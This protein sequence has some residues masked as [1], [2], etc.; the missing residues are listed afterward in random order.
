M[1]RAILAVAVLCLLGQPAQAEWFSFRCSFDCSGWR[2]CT[3][4]WCARCGDCMRSGGEKLSAAAAAT[5]DWVCERTGWFQSEAAPAPERHYGLDVPPEW[6]GQEPLIVLV[7]G[8][9]SG[10]DCW[11]DLAPLLTDSGYAVAYFNYPNDQPIAESGRLLSAELAAFRQQHDNVGLDLITHSMGGLVVR[12]CLEGAEYP[13]GV[14]RFIQLSPP[15]HG[16]KYR[17]WSCCAETFEHFL[18]WREF[19]DWNWSWPFDDGM[20]EAGHDLRADSTLLSELNA[21]PRRAGVAY[22]IVAGN[23]NCGWRYTANVLDWT[24]AWLP[25][26]AYDCGLRRCLLETAAQLRTRTGDSDGLVTLDSARLAGVDDFLVLPAD[27]LTICRSYDAAPPAAW[28]TIRH[29]LTRPG[30]KTPAAATRTVAN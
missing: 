1:R 6:N 15:T 5:R 23:R 29:R 14:R 24:A 22:T 7:H 11:Q 28:E 26:C 9:D 13:G 8:L 20:G 19:D 18:L 21:R 12:W 2:E 25:E 4:R 16:A 27:H 17:R 30:G 3:Q 10:A